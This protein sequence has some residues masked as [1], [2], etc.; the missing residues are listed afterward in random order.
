MFRLTS[1]EKV[2]VVANCD[3]LGN[4]KYSNVLPYAFTEHGTIMAASV[5]NTP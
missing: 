1:E 2:E 5:L 4:I 3:L